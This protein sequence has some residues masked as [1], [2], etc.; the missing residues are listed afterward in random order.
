MPIYKVTR[1]VSAR[2]EHIWH[3]VSDVAHWAD[4][5]ETVDKVEAL[6]GSELTV[7]H[8]F[9][10]EQPGLRPGVWEVT[11]VDPEEGFE[12]VSR[13][14]GFVM[15]ADHRI[16]RGDARTSILSLSF[17]FSGLL[18]APVGYLF[19]RKTSDFLNRE[20]G[21]FKSLG[22]GLARGIS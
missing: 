16:A 17:R 11:K 9:R 22:E 14:S 12:W 15:T 20:I 10:L 4:L 5:L 3:F 7:G 13:A 18:G 2:P 19:G 1:S 6:D 8:R 21:T